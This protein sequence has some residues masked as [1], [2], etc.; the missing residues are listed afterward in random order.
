MIARWEWR[1]FGPRF[2]DLD[3]RIRAAS[4][5][6]RT[7][8]DTYVLST[9]S[10]ANVKVR[11]GLLDVKLRDRAEDGLE[12]WHP[13][14]KAS[15]PVPAETIVQ[16]FG[17]WGLPAPEHLRHAYTLV[18]LLGDLVA[19]RPELHAVVVAKRREAAEIDGC[20][21]ESAALTFD[22]HPVHTI[23]IESADPDRVRRVVRSLGYELGAN[24]NYVAALKSLLGIPAVI[25]DSR[26]RE[27]A[28]L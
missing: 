8:V 13:A 14:L 3:A 7:G 20:L 2:P 5:E 1:A 21:A 22:G 27:G 17:Y 6:T 9:A 25:A 10:D 23:A 16:V 4:P 12:L 28:P 15:F 24:I 26:A 18:E 19:P 11:H